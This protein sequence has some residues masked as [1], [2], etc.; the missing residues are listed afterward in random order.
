MHCLIVLEAG[1]TKPT[2]RQGHTLSDGSRGKSFFASSSF[3]CLLSILGLSMHHS[4]HKSVFSL[5]VIIFPLPV[6]VSVQISPFSKE[7]N[8]IIR[9]Q[10][11]DFIFLPSHS[12]NPP[13]WQPP[14]CSLYPWLFLFSSF[15]LIFLDSTYKRDHMVYVFLSLTYFT[16]DNT[17]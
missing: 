5:C 15:I 1:S 16:S 9:A 11:N 6:C 17:L 13:H 14:T 2:Y 8:H 12:P 7:I 3:W 4:S 10:P